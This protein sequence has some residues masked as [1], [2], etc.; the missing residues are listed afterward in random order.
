MIAFL[1]VMTTLF[2]IHLA[3]ASQV[4]VFAGSTREASV[5]K[6]LAI[7]AADI[8]SSLGAK[9]TYIDLKDYPIPLYD[10]DLEDR[11]GMPAN[12]KT[13][14]RLIVQNQALIIASPNH[15]GSVSA[16]LKN[17]IDWATRGENGGDARDVFKGKK[18][19]I[20]SASPGPSGGSAGLPHLESIIGKLGGIVMSKKVAI[21]KAYEAFDE[22]GLL[23]NQKQRDELKQEIQQLLR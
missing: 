15:N 12:A 5:N 19:A 16:V 6:K 13:I 18:F 3:A 4:L 14:R 21:P 20:M 1:S 11:E 8:A 17:V 9:V 7:Q 23:K 22:N 10:G 2:S